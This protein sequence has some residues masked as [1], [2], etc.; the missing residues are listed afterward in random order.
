[1]FFAIKELSL[2]DMFLGDYLNALASFLALASRFGFPTSHVELTVIVPENCLACL[3][4]NHT[5]L[6]LLHREI[7]IGNVD[8]KTENRKGQLS[9]LYKLLLVHVNIRTLG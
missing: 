3:C 1:M 5:I 9:Q 7:S 4:Q 6:V 8:L 2:V